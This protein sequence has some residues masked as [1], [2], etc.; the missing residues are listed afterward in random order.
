MKIG[1]RLKEAR[2]ANHYSQ[3]EVS[4]ILHVS[5]ST[6]SSWE[7]GRTYPSIELLVELSKLYDLSLDQLLKEDEEII[8]EFKKDQQY[9]KWVVILGIVIIILLLVL[10]ISSFNVSEKAIASSHLL[11]T[12]T[13]E[14]AFE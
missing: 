9:K 10:L 3:Q 12:L 7:I 6:I 14:G 4:E 11:I 8:K 2:T 5:R 1:Q 13:Q